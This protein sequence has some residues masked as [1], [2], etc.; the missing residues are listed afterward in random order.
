MKH[1]LACRFLF[2]VLGLAW[3]PGMAAC[4]GPDTSAPVDS[5]GQLDV[6]PD[7]CQQTDRYGAPELDGPWDLTE[8][9]ASPDGSGDGPAHDLPD[10]TLLSDS[11]DAGAHADLM[12]SAEIDETLDLAEVPAQCDAGSGAECYDGPPGTLGVGECQAGLAVCDLGRWPV[13]QGQI[14][15]QD[16]SCDGRDNDCD[17]QTDENVLGPCED[18]DAACGVFA[19]G[20]GFPTPFEISAEDSFGVALD[21]PGALLFSAAALPADH[22]WV[23]NSFD[24]TMS[25]LSAV[26]GKELGQT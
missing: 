14:V 20:V 19:V 5:H 16:E 17:G 1:C 13:C 4:S 26:D 12:E 18:C 10:A 3:I 8:H 22:V 25:K 2:S 21:D 23:P 6:F 15:P 24:N 7:V 11:L 9:L